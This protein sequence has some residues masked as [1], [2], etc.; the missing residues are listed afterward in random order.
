MSLFFQVLIDGVLLGGI[1]ACIAVSFSLIWGV[2]NLINLAHGT[3]VV[4]GAYLTIVA[5]K[6]LGLDPFLTLPI[7][8]VTMFCFGYLIQRYLINLIIKGSIFMVLIF[9][10]GLDLLLKNLAILGFTADPQSLSTAYAFSGFEFGV[11]TVPYIKIAVFGAALAITGLLAVFLHRT[12][13]GWAIKAVSFDKD[14]AQLVGINIAKTYALTFAVGAGIA[15]AAGSLVAV[16]YTFSPFTGDSLTMMSFV[17]VVL[18]GLGSISGAIIG[19]VLL[20][21][22]ENVGTLVLSPGYRDVITFF[23]LLAV[24]LCRPQGLLGKSFYAE[25]K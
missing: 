2:L 15:G 9:T 24:L 6:M 17:V 22:A 10:F 19:A 4:L 1:Y 3:M 18:G 8:G 25:V 21:V 13:F 5:F 7:A 23:V 20:A 16:T 11:I 12:R 14:A